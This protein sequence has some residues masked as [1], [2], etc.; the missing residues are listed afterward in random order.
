MLPVKTSYLPLSASPILRNATALNL[1]RC[2]ARLHGFRCDRCEP[3][4]A[5][6]PPTFAPLARPAINRE[7]GREPAPHGRGPAD[8]TLAL[9]RGVAQFWVVRLHRYELP[10]HISLQTQAMYIVSGYFFRTAPRLF[11]SSKGQHHRPALHELPGFPIGGR[12]SWQA[13]SVY[14]AAHDRCILLFSVWRGWQP[15]IDSIPRSPRP[16]L[17]CARVCGLFTGAA[18]FVDAVDRP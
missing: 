12:D 16:I 6:G 11:R 10:R 2:R 14:R 5:Q 13:H 7:R 1:D 17:S 18:P 9:I 4:Q 15:G 8:F 3:R